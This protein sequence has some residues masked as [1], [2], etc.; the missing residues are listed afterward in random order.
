[1]NSFNP[2]L[3]LPWLSS[4]LMRSRDWPLGCVRNFVDS[5]SIKAS[6][7]SILFYLFHF[8]QALSTILHLFSKHKAQNT[9]PTTHTL[10]IQN[11][12]SQIY[13]LHSRNHVHHANHHLRS[14][15]NFS[16]ASPSPTQSPPTRP[17]F[18][19]PGSHLHIPHRRL[20]G[21]HKPNRPRLGLR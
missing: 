18:N 21:P 8:F 6:T 5:L 14:P 7:P 1:M 9:H 13:N 17:Y 4:R 16:C 15:C 3:A 2:G 11:S 20:M 12:Y 10:E 19:L